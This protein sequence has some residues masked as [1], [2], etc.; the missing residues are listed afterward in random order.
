M[1]GK[2]YR[3]SQAKSR[4][5]GRHASRLGTVI[6]LKVLR[7]SK[8]GTRLGY[9]PKKLRVAYPRNKKT[10]RFNEVRGLDWCVYA[11]VRRPFAFKRGR[12]SMIFL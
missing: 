7:W 12:G 5:L 6:M 2:D 10:P 8:Y 1:F 3:F 4:V 9:P 11:S